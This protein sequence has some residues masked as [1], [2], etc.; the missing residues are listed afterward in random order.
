MNFHT[1]IKCYPI[2]RIKEIVYIKGVINNPTNP[3][4]KLLASLYYTFI[5]FF[6]VKIDFEKINFNDVTFSTIIL[7]EFIVG[8]ICAGFIVH[9]IIQ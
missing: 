4:R 5:L 2:I 8:L 9:L 3:A 1:I 6:G 7:T